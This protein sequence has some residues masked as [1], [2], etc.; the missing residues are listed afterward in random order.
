LTASPVACSPYPGPSAGHSRCSSDSSQCSPTTYLQAPF[1]NTLFSP[2]PA[3]PL[4]RGLVPNPHS[5]SPNHNTA[6]TCDRTASP[7][8]PHFTRSTSPAAQ[9]YTDISRRIRGP[10]PGAGTRPRRRSA[11]PAVRTGTG[12]G[13]TVPAVPAVAPE[14]TEPALS[15]ALCGR[16]TE[17]IQTKEQEETG[18]GPVDGL[19]IR[20]IGRKRAGRALV[21][22]ERR[23]GRGTHRG[24]CR[25]D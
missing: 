3:S 7:S 20:Q 4:P 24:N 6:T 14:G 21:T 17:R 5:T 9:H 1:P 10:T 25:V 12:A 8:A 2:L 15:A 19:G 18:P 23:T 22:Q 11:F 13:T 16:R